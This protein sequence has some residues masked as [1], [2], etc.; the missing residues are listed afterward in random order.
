VKQ[1]K[2]GHFYPLKRKKEELE[3]IKKRK[4]DIEVYN[5]RTNK[6]KRIII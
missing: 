2:G 4:K 6:R 3:G 5:E 1:L